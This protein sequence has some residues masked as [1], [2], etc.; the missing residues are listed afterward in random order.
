MTAHIISQ[1]DQEITIQ[2]KISLKKTML[3]S[4]ESILDS[5]NQVGVLATEEALKQFDTDGEPI[6]IGGV[7]WTSRCL[8]EKKYQTPYGVARLERHAYQTSQGGKVYI[9]L[10]SGARII[11][12]ATPRFAKMLSHKYSN[13]AAP[14]LCFRS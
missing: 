9:P 13:L 14:F 3:E 2:I 4:E 8:T 5:V 10:E 1:T 7:K 6:V 12:G 11:Q